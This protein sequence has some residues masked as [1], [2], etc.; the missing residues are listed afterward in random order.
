[1]EFADTKLAKTILAPSFT[2]P[3]TSEIT[4][5]EIRSLVIDILIPSNQRLTNEERWEENFGSLTE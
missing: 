4:D 1:M 3:Q 5:E 2:I